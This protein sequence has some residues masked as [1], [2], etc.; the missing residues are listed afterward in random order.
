MCAFNHDTEKDWDSGRGGHFIAL[1][2]QIYVLLQGYTMAV[3][4]LLKNLKKE[5]E[6]PLC[7]EILKNPR[8]LPCLHS[9]CLECLDRQ[10]K[11]EREQLQTS[12]RCSICRTSIEIPETDTFENL[13]TSFHLKRLVDILALTDP[14]DSDREQA[15]VCNSCEENN[16]PICYCFVCQNFLCSSCLESH[17]R[18]RATRGHRNV[19][20]NNLQAQDVQ[21]LMER[22]V[23]CSQSHHE[24]QPLEFYCKDCKLLICNK[25]SVVRH[26][27]HSITDIHIAAQEQKMQIADAV[28]KVNAEITMYENEI[29]KQNELRNKI[30]TEVKNVEEKIT[31]TVK[32]LID[33][34]QEHERI[35]KDKIRKINEAQQKQHEERLDI[36]ERNTAQLKSC[37]ERCQSI[38]KRNSSNE[39]LQSNNTILDRCNELLKVQKPGI[40]RSPHLHYFIVK[41]VDI[42]DKVLVTNTDPSMCL[43]GGRGSKEI[44]EKNETTFV[45]VTRDSEG[46]PCYQQ[47]DQVEVGIF[48]PDNGELRP[49]IQD[50]KDG[51]YSITYTPQCAGRHRVQI[52]VNGQ[53]LAGSPWFVPVNRQSYRYKFSFVFGSQGNG[54]GEV[55]QPFDT[56]VSRKTGAIAVPDMQNKKIQLFCSD[57]KFLREVRVLSEPFSVAFTDIGHLLI[58][59]PGSDNKLHLMSEEGQLIRYINDKHLEQPEHLS[60]ASDGRIIVCD[61]AGDKIKVLSP[62]G[63]DLLQS[64]I[65]PGCDSYPYGAICHQ[66]KYFVSY[67][68][69]HCVKVFDQTGKHLFDIGS[70]GSKDGLFRWPRGLIIDKYN[71]LI[72]S[73]ANN[74]RLQF[75]T[76]DG[77]FLHK[78]QGDFFSNGCPLYVTIS[79]DDSLFVADFQKHC[80][81]VFK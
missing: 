44:I 68:D 5:A 72:V 26:N 33:D 15:R 40:Y 35:M 61:L 14:A 45:V 74:Q 53:P 76:L 39:I 60:V 29:K 55:N 21:D 7:L 41:N 70:K 9:F 30:E 10:A 37:V 8:T 32:K 27:R 36:L 71:Q 20:L 6:C 17:R 13:P 12:I 3:Q 34:L 46:L 80:I 75:F 31:R 50:T 4:Q 69:S 43:A 19:F 64:F 25:C 48:T 62:D 79:N 81:F 24:D 2:T 52:Q 16:P 28:D 42:V 67:P 22:P 56:A 59:V 51:R 47:D 63:N 23:M 49:N 18:L 57:G 11:F 73:D 66:E 77:K 65:A 54:P 58:L 38:I 78:L 1:G